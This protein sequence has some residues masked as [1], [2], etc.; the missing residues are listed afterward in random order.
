MSEPLN[1]GNSS[2]S[3][4]D[5]DNASQ[6]SQRSSSLLERIRMQREREKQQS[7]TQQQPESSSTPSQMQIQVPQYNPVPTTSPEDVNLATG[8]PDPAAAASAAARR[9]DH[10]ATSA[11]PAGASNFFR[12]A[13]N[14]IATSMETGMASLENDGD[15]LY[16]A[17]HDSDNMEDALLMMPTASRNW[18]A[19]SAAIDEDYSMCNYFLVFV[20]DV[21]LAFVSVPLP[22]RVI[23]VVVLLYVAIKLL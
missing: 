23:L 18:G 7:Q 2:S 16:F 3:L 6:S 9:P 20:R 21:Y 15:G 22:G 12:S 19:G 10:L 5:D 4:L 11:A 1:R 8:G 13:W 17:G 14:N